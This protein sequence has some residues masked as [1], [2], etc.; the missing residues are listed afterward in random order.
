[1]LRFLFLFIFAKAC[2]PVDAQEVRQVNGFSYTIPKRT[3]RNSYERAYY[4][5]YYRNYYSD[6]YS[7]YSQ[8]P[9]QS[10]GFQSA[11]PQS[12]FSQPA[13]PSFQQVG[14]AN[15]YLDRCCRSNPVISPGCYELCNFDSFDFNRGFAL[16]R[17]GQCPASGFGALKDCAG[18]GVD[19]T[20][21]CSQS[22]VHAHCM[23]FCS[24]GMP[25]VGIRQLKC[26]NYINP[27]KSCMRSYLDR[28]AG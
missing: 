21:C 22:G 27:I 7:R 9:A 24:P 12:S 19:H 23:G 26:R 6:Y 16:Y 17:S 4:E 8:S 10:S 13:Q 2:G 1:M 3:Y 5:N 28:A 18:G 20:S 14:G 25:A 15:A 11:Q